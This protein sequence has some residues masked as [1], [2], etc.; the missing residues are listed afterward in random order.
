MPA[1]QLAHLLRRSVGP[2]Q[3]DRE[4]Q[5]AIRLLL[6]LE[7]ETHDP[8]FMSSQNLKTM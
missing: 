6:V 8:T 5:I 4:A 1:T 7:P 2:Q 3:S